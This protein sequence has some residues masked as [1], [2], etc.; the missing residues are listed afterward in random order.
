MGAIQS[1]K[2]SEGAFPI[3]CEPCSCKL[4]CMLQHLRDEPMMMRGGKTLSAKLRTTLLPARPSQKQLRGRASERGQGRSRQRKDFNSPFS[5]LPAEELQTPLAS[6]EG[7]LLG[8]AAFEH[9]L[10]S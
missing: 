8:L 9:C 10:T 2:R 4:G 6:F 3:G 7:Q 5:G 1:H